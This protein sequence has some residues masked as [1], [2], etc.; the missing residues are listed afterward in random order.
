MCGV[1]PGG[2][3]GNN[4]PWLVV[5]ASGLDAHSV[6]MQELDGVG[7]AIVALRKV[8]TELGG[9]HHMAELPSEGLAAS[10]IISNGA[11]GG[12]RSVAPAAAIF[13]ITQFWRS[14][15]RMRATRA[16]SGM[17]W[18]TRQ[19]GD[20]VWDGCGAA[21]APGGGGGGGIGASC[22]WPLCDGTMLRN[23]GWDASPAG[24]GPAAMTSSSMH[25][26]HASLC[27]SIGR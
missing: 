3:W 1:P 13:Y 23:G 9:P 4:S 25:V 5:A 11:G 26:V 20:E 7:H 15:W 17:R 18:R 19:S 14:R 12:S 10:T 24:I 8:R 27:A 16:S 6:E 2:P 21:R 22:A